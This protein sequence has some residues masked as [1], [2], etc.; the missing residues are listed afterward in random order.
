MRLAVIPGDGI[1]IEVTEQALRVLDAVL[2]GV[3]ATHVRPRRGTV[4]PHRRDAARRGARGDCAGTTRSCSARWAIRP[5]RPACSSAG[6][7][8]DCASNSTIT[9]TCVRPGCTRAS[10]HRWPVSRRSTSSSCAKA[11][12]ARTPA[13]GE[14]CAR[15]PRTRS[16]P[17][18]RVNTAYGVERV[19]RDAFARAQARPRKHLTLVHKNNVLDQ[20]GRSVV[21]H[22]AARRA[23]VPRRHRRL[24]P[25]GRRDDLPG[26]RSGTLRRHRHRQPVRRHRH[27][28]RRGASRAES[29]LLPAG[30][31]TSAARTP[32]CS[33]RCTARRRT[34]PVRARPTRRPPCCRSS[35]LL[36]H[37]GADDAAATGRG[38]G[39]GMTSRAA[40]RK[41][42]GSTGE[43]GERLAKAAAS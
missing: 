22:R 27:R 8:F 9:S 23:G 2:P 1:G 4:A 42:P 17:R 37:L 5:C 13:T 14:C 19:V 10:P 38:G 32:R 15:A 31:S 20:R 6:C 11:P 28:P 7:C 35:M 39:R 25:R 33:S 21:P 12:R 29:A 36:A 26:H 3:E 40:T 34:S 16:P 18:S 41:Q 30:I 43:I 24:Q